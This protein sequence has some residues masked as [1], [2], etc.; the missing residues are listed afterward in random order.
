MDTQRM[1]AGSTL[2]VPGEPGIAIRRDDPLIVR[3][4]FQDEKGVWCFAVETEQGKR[5]TVACGHLRKNP[6][7]PPEPGRGPRMYA[8][9]RGADAPG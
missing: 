3:E 1:W 9:E 7:L 6:P 2:G 5:Y 8:N 4:T